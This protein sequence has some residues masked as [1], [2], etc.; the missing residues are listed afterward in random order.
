MKKV[1]A[2]VLAAAFVSITATGA[3]AQ[4]VPFVQFTFDRNMTITAMDCPGTSA[5]VQSGY[6]VAVNFNVFFT[7]I[8]YSVAYSP[9]MAYLGDVKVNDNQL[10]I[11]SSNTGIS[12]AWSLPM[13]GFEPINILEVLFTW[14][15]DNGCYDPEAILVGTN[16]TTG[17]LQ[18]TRWPDNELFSA[19]GMTSLVCP[20]AVPVEDTSWGGI[21]ALYE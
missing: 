17:L 1:L 3:M 16:P 2:V 13:S 18:Y 5:D 8:E 20:G 21:K 11:G 9:M 7:A 6:I 12:S 10:N 4:P 15:C 19:I 14:S